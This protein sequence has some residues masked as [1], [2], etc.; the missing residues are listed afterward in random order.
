MST[1]I[2]RE[3]STVRLMIEL[4][5]RHK[6]GN[7]ELCPSCMALIDY[8]EARL[9]RCPF[10]NAKSSCRHCAIHCYRPDMKARIKAVM[11][12]SGPRMLIYRPLEALSHLLR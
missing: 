4:Y 9:S 5:C 2:K 1:R 11:R 6:E 7:R 10:G 3:K 8:A 12:Y